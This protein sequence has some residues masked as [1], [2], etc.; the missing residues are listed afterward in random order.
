M[1]TSNNEIKIISPGMERRKLTNKIHLLDEN[2][3]I[4]LSKKIDSS[5]N[6]VQDGLLKVIQELAKCTLGAFQANS[7]NLEAI[8]ELMKISVSIENDL[9]RQ[10]EDSDCS[11]ENIAN[12]L[13]DLCSQYN[14]DSHAIE[15]LF[16]QSFNRTIT[17]RTRINNL[18]EEFFERISKNEEKFDHFDETIQKKEEEFTSCFDSKTAEYKKQLEISID[19]YQK[20]LNATKNSYKQEI[21]T[22]KYFLMESIKQHNVE[23]S[24]QHDT[25]FKQYERENTVLKNQMYMLTQDVSKLQNRSTWTLSIS[26]IATIVAAISFAV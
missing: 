7:E 13:H 20:E 11:K 26:I 21:E 22:L 10:L 18:R 4:A 3:F 5:F 24:K 16:E 15:V 25:K 8:L 19:K 12:L 17:L 1:K 9:Y 2:K 14:I 6:V 23:V